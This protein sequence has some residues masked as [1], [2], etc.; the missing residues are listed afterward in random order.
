MNFEKFYQLNRQVLNTN[1]LHFCSFKLIFRLS[2]CSKKFRQA[3][4]AKDGEIH[5]KIIAATQLLNCGGGDV[6]Q[7][8]DLDAI[9]HILK[10]KVKNISDFRL[11]NG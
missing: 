2:L 7:S 8:F 1:F 5:L 10:V 4:E 3:I 6:M 9:D 11:L